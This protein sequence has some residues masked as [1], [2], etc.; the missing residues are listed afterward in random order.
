LLSIASFI[1]ATT[2]GRGGSGEA[3]TEQRPPSIPAARSGHAMAYDDA[4]HVVLLF[5]ENG[6]ATLGARS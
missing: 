3:P 2:C 5:G 6:S 1:V 4:R